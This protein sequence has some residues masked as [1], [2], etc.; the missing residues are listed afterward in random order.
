MSKKEGVFQKIGEV[1]GG[2]VVSNTAKSIIDR[3]FERLRTNAEK[4]TEKTIKMLISVIFFILGVI[5]LVT[6]SVFL[7]HEYF[8]LSI[9]WIV[10]M[11]GLLM[12]LFSIGFRLSVKE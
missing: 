9:G 8:G 6:A 7:I 1:L 2:K 3:F 11:L 10:L 5:L 4:F 12:F